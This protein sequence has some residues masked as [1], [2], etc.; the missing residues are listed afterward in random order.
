MF[1][2]GVKNISY[3]SCSLISIIRYKIFICL[4]KL[5][6]YTCMMKQFNGKIMGKEQQMPSIHLMKPKTCFR[7]LILPSYDNFMIVSRL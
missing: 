4:K 2:C 6:I 7:R 5:D 3:W 1:S